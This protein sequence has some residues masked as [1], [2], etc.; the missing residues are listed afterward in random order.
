MTF[1]QV[2]NNLSEGNAATMRENLGFSDAAKSFVIDATPIQGM[3]YGLTLSNNGTDPTNDIDIAPGMAADATGSQFMRLSSAFTKRLDA[4]WSAGTNHGMR[5]S[6]AA[7]TNTTYHIYLA[8]TF[9]G[10]VDIYADPS[11]DAVT[12]LAHLQAETG[13]G[14]YLV[15][16]RIGSIVR[17]GGAILG[18]TQLG[19]E[20]LWKATN[21][22][23]VDVINPGTSALT[24]TLLVPTG[25]QFT[26]I[27]QWLFG[28]VTPSSANVL[29]VTSF[30]QTDTAPDFFGKQSFSYATMGT[31]DVHV[32]GE[33]RTRT[34]TSGQVRYRLG[35][36]TA[37]VFV[38]AKASGWLDARGRLY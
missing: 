16:R 24:A 12:A 23:T 7:I 37:S 25:I 22:W 31:V 11:A 6:G 35:I 18:F 17:A 28:D 26:A 19:D 2:A 33:L 4:N 3:L 9:L 15:V 5:Y 13:G 36:S 32:T 30:D 27:T 14:G 1:F 21:G 34:N 29:L 20:F 38:G 8:M 10:G